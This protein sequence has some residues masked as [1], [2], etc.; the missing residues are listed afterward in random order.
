MFTSL[1]SCFLNG[2]EGKLMKIEIDISPG[3][4]TFEIGGLPDA[5]VKESKGRV[6]S[7]IKN[8]H[9]EYPQKRITVNLA[10]SN[11]P[12]GGSQLDL[13]IALGILTSSGQL[14]GEHF[15]DIVFVGEL[16]L[17]GQI[18]GVEGMLSMVIALVEGQVPRLVLP[19]QNYDEVKVLEEKIELI[20][21]NSLQDV[22]AYIET[23]RTLHLS[24][25]QDCMT[26]KY[27]RTDEPHL[28]AL[29]ELD[30]NQIKGQEQV[31]RAL[32]VAVAGRHNVLLI[33]PP[34]TGKTMLAKRLPSIMPELDFEEALEVTRIYSVAGDLIKRNKSGLIF[35][36]PVRM[37]HHGI[38]ESA[39][40]G[41][42]RVPKPGEISLA[43][44]GVLVL[45]EFSEY[46]QRQ[47]DMLRQPL[48]D[49][50]VTVSRFNGT[51]VFPAEFMLVATMNPCPCGYY[52][53]P[54]KTCGCT[55]TQIRR[56]LNKL[57]GPLWDRVDLQ[58]EVPPIQVSEL[59]TEYHGESS[60]LIRMRVMQARTLQ[61]ERYKK[62]GN[63][64]ATMSQQQINQYC[65]LDSDTKDLLES[66]YRKLELSVRG[67]DKIL[68]VARTIADL[69]GAERISMSDIAE[70][71]HYRGLDRKYI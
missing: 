17:D 5:S 22:V 53:V 49:G 18:R 15:E 14:R 24:D 35:V 54:E 48:E 58:V 39:L 33:G 26:D 60:S 31:K 50:Q 67:Y 8:S 70:A 62:T 37:P 46:N 7:A 27:S 9:F 65:C 45:D 10:P 57:N 16:S 19:S 13:A 23:G 25:T 34:G 41:G 36:P 30:F 28:N 47:L 61:K 12:K 56:Y 69:K 51:C 1:T 68:K 43:H 32:E 66:V 20:P 21:V 71:S 55:D 63:Y 3:L 38:T 4:P 42:G 52:G 2:I 44:R 11:I 64:N 6:R 40:I 59:T 29:E